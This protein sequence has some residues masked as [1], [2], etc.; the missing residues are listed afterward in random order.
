MGLVISIVILRAAIN[1]Q[2]CLLGASYQMAIV[3]A[4]IGAWNHSQPPMR[5]DFR[6]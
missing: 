5:C 2:P 4:A 1:A 3:Q 6:R